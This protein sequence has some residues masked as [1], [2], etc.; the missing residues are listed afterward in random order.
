M[1]M[2]GT[3]SRNYHNNLY[4]L[5]VEWSAKHDVANNRSTITAR[6]KIS[7]NTSGAS[8]YSI[9]LAN[10]SITIDGTEK[11]FTSAKV[12]HSGIKTTTLGTV[13]QVVNHNSDGNK[14]LTIKGY[15]PFAGTIGGTYYASMSC[16]GSATLNKITQAPN[17]PTGI[18][19]TRDSDTSHKITWSHSATGL[20]PVTTFRLQRWDI[21]TG[22]YST[23]TTLSGNTKSY[24]DTKT[25]AN[26]IYIYRV[27]AEN[28]AGNSSYKTSSQIKTTPSAP[29]SVV[30]KQ[31]GNNIKI[32]WKNNYYTRSGY[33][34]V[35]GNRIEV[36]K[37]GG[38]YSLLANVDASNT[39]YVY[40]N[41]GGGYYTF[42]I[43]A[44]TESLN[45]SYATSSEVRL[46]FIP[47]I[48]SNI[49]L[50]RITDN[51]LKITWTNNST[52]NEPYDNI[53]IQRW[54]NV[55]GSWYSKAVVAGNI[56]S[57]TDTTTQ[58]NRNYQYRIR[59][60]NTAGDSAYITTPAIDTTPAKP[61][62][63][64][65][66]RQ[67][68]NVNI[69]WI[70]KA[71][72]AEIIRIQRRTKNNGI[73]GNYIDIKTVLSN[74]EVY[75]DIAPGGGVHQYRIRAESINLTSDWVT[76]TEVLTLQAPNAPSNLSPDNIAIEQKTDVTFTWKY[77]SIDGTEQ[78]S[79]EIRYK[80]KDDTEWTNVTKNSNLKSHTF[81]GETF[82]N[83]E[84]YLWQVR[85]K[86]QHAN[87]SDWS[88]TAS[89]VTALK[90]VIDITYPIDIHEYP[91]LTVKWI[92]SNVGNHTQT[93]YRIILYD[94]DIEIYNFLGY[95]EDEEHTLDYNLE[96]NKTYKLTIQA[97]NDLNLISDTK[98][99]IFEVE[100]A[101]PERA[102]IEL[103][104]IKNE[105]KVI[106]NVINPEGEPEAVFNR[107]YRQI[108]DEKAILI[109]DNLSPNTAFID[110]IPT[111]AGKNS[112]FVVTV[113][114]LPSTN[115]SFKYDLNI[116]ARGLYFINSGNDWSK[117]IELK[118][119]PEITEEINRS[120]SFYQ[121]EGRKLP[122][123][124]QGTNIKHTLDLSFYI[125]K[126]DKKT[127]E[128]IINN[129][130]E[131]YYR[132]HFGNRFKCGIVMSKLIKIDGETFEFI[133]TII[134]IENK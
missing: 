46:A 61:E 134:E 87:Y 109:A 115:T 132:D 20:R 56:N 70:N 12:S 50:T 44:Y 53:E 101:I 69:N 95:G 27:R 4:T 33:T 92:Y 36:S 38:S 43:R 66:S 130:G 42:R 89:F 5:K 49:S 79:Y 94:N 23:I 118:Y 133:C 105:G 60:K 102:E 80:L 65:V 19:I 121:F 7:S 122:V 57:Y 55:T 31:E 64:S 98:E 75:L 40:S 103:E 111:I 104:F 74:I 2:S 108:N 110:Y 35:T 30:G 72:N 82:L 83:E 37:D 107:V 11:K 1:A 113:S 67:E 59:A 17:A 13:T 114:D 117:L 84:E 34:L 21:S 28:A 86:G 8:L 119:K 47:A 124:Y 41:P 71:S 125:D 45:S 10:S 112:Y 48:P 97:R 52:T 29:S 14:T 68:L 16:S 116:N 18:A 131:L 100:Y 76:S 15:W 51:Q 81:T 127:L 77:N 78:T 6:L 120:T 91:D 22:A 3:I 62:N 93:S 9:A 63:I 85:T 24:T 106:I 128:E 54:D 96:H 39:S 88:N 90:P 25:V 32:T 129:E 123:M 73:W 126:K 26:R 58:S 99:I